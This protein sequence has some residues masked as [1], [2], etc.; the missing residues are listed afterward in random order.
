MFRGA[1]PYPCWVVGVVWWRSRCRAPGVVGLWSGG[2][3]GIA[4]PRGCVSWDALPIRWEFRGVPNDALGEG[5]SGDGDRDGPDSPYLREA[6]GQSGFDIVSRE[7]GGVEV[8]EGEEDD[9]DDEGDD[10][11]DGA[12]DD[13]LDGGEAELESGFDWAT[14]SWMVTDG[15]GRMT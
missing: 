8:G 15:S 13:G 1:G 3:A 7:W 10:A 6:W 4:G 9:C 12:E 11:D 2:P 14:P 5:V